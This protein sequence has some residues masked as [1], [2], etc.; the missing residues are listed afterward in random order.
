MNY[1]LLCK[2]LTF[3]NWAFVVSFVSLYTSYFLPYN[4]NI[5]VVKVTESNKL[6]TYFSYFRMLQIISWMD[7]R[8]CRY[9]RSKPKRSPQHELKLSIRTNHFSSMNY[10]ECKVNDLKFISFNFKELK[11][12]FFLQNNCSECRFDI[13]D[14]E[15]QYYVRFFKILHQSYAW[16]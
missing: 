13:L 9:S 16:K 15:L 7:Q 12:S 6:L 4:G 3:F 8:L 11:V 1:F 5:Y 2:F 10:S 14:W